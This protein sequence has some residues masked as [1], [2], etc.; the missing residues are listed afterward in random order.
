MLFSRPLIELLNFFFISIFT[1]LQHFSMGKKKKYNGARLQSNILL[2][3][4]SIVDSGPFFPLD[5]S[6]LLSDYEP[7]DSSGNVVIRFAQK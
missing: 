1:D 6:E 2:I 7:T 4:L 3:I 5:F